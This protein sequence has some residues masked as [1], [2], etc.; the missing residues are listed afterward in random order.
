MGSH[1][2]VVTAAKSTAFDKTHCGYS[3]SWTDQESVSSNS[4]H[5]TWLTDLRQSGKLS[6]GNIHSNPTNASGYAARSSRWCATAK[7]S[8]KRTQPMRC[9]GLDMASMAKSPAHA[10]GPP[11]D[12]HLAAG[13][14][15]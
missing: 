6:N 10:F 13:F 4:N 14:E 8:I 9:R 2:A 5:A 11:G 1:I 15:R 7:V 12:L 3:G